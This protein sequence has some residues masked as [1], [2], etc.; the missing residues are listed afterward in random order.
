[1]VVVDLLATL[2]ALL[3]S[4]ISEEYLDAV[5]LHPLDLKEGGQ[6][7]QLLDEPSFHDLCSSLHSQQ[8]V[9]WSKSSPSDEELAIAG[10]FALNNPELRV[11]RCAFA[12]P[13][14]M[15]EPQCKPWGVLTESIRSVRSLNGSY[16]S[17]AG[18]HNVFL[19]LSYHH[20]LLELTHVVLAPPLPSLSVK[21]TVVLT[22][23]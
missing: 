14:W 19:A 10:V 18:T 17:S 15:K 16:A 5:G 11:L 21:L 9:L 4:T 1:M 23:G 20:R 8:Q 22:A 13:R 2:S 3:A 12:A 6:V 7:A